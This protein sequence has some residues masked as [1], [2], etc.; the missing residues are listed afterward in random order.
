MGV[1]PCGLAARGAA[2]AA[3]V[4][5]LAVS[6]C[7]SNSGEPSH[8]LRYPLVAYQTDHPWRTQTSGVWEATWLRVQGVASRA[9]VAR[10]GPASLTFRLDDLTAGELRT[11]IGLLATDRASTGSTRFAVRVLHAAT[12]QPF[13]TLFDETLE[14]GPLR[15]LRLRLPEEAF[16]IQLEVTPDSLAQESGA[17]PVWFDPVLA[18]H[19]PRPI[20]N[21]D[22]LSVLLITV[23]TLRAD[24]L[25]SYGGPV[26]TP[27]LERLVRRGVRFEDAHSVAFG[28][29]PSHASLLT[30]RPA[31]A[32][33]VH[34]NLGVLRRDQLTLAEVLAEQ[35][36][37][38]AAFV[39][40]I[41]LSRG[42]NLVQGF[43][44][45]DDAFIYD[46]EARL[47]GTARS[48]RRADRTREQMFAWLDS[49]PPDEPFFAWVHWF[50][51]HQPYD[52]PQPAG[53]AEGQASLLRASAL[54]KRSKSEFVRASDEAWQRYLGE[55]GFVDRELGIL[56]DRIEP[57]GDV[58]V[59][60]T[61]D[62]GETFLDRAPHLAFDH[63]TLHREVTRVPLV[64]A[65]PGKL[66]AAQV[67]DSLAASTDIAPT[68]L[69]LLGIPVPDR[70]EG[71]DLLPWLGPSPP[72]A[73][74][75][76][77]LQFEGAGRSQ[78]A[79]RTPDWLYR[80]A[81]KPSPRALHALGFDPGAAVA[82]HSLSGEEAG[83][84][85]VIGQQPDVARRLAALI[86]TG[87]QPAERDPAATLELD[88]GHRAALEQ[89]GYVDP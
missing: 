72:E 2:W 82:L 30:S 18:R 39:S 54:L 36:Y 21:P 42:L 9:L 52:P 46:L 26:P 61:A 20:R 80:V 66:P 85:N 14:V 12:D 83:S 41:P 24:A 49:L 75:H 78:L 60:F 7:G 31:R 53:A 81:R 43:D 33:G 17:W 5:L 87:E 58:I 59:V 89:L 35:G 16:R 13:D 70:F 64:V 68:V 73:P 51:P 67:F 44:L 25:G 69:G 76:A 4:C 65:A 28:T 32:H 47:G 74:P 8:T 23:D 48:Q 86:D 40:G 84:G 79:I 6:G 11:R 63:T 55:V 29:T 22:A 57:R 50:D 19:A 77:Y 62:H 10:Q 15:D 45:Y 88:A 56:L 37:H 3:G 1:R 71:I 27:S 38:T 34:D